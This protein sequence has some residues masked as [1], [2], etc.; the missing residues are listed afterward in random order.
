MLNKNNNDDMTSK[1]KVYSL[2]L[3]IL[4]GINN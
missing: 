3:Y 4:I 2:S 1:A